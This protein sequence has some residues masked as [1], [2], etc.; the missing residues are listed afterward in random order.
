MPFGAIIDSFS[1]FLGGLLGTAIASRLSDRLKDDLNMIFGICAM[2]MGISNVIFMGNLSA[3]VLSVIIGTLL[4]SVF[5]MEHG[6]SEVG[7]AL[8]RLLSKISGPSEEA[9]PAAY[10]QLMITMIILFCASGTGIYGAV[11]SGISSDHSILI[12]KAIL[13]FFTA[14]IFACSAGKIVSLIAIPQLLV[15]LFMYFVGRFIYPFTT[16]YMIN[17]FKAV[18]GILMIAT[19]FR[20]LKIK[21]LPTASMLPSMLL[22]FPLSYLWEY[23]MV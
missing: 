14:M 13:D 18:G 16:Q 21:M 4:G 9:D 22:V 3:V 12:S 10:Q 8:Q 17:N 1:L 15:L 20:M 11:I 7:K 6:I 5:Y 23:Y 2:V 19:A